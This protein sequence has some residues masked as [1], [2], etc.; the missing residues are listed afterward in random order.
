MLKNIFSENPEKKIA[1]GFWEKM[2]DVHAKKDIFQKTQEK[3]I[4]PKD[5][6][7][8]YSLYMLKTTFSRK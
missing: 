7:K 4:L 1:Q 2:F 6:T 8:I 3:H 5:L